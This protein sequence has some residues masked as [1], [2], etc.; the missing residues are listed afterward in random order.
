MIS[1]RFVENMPLI[2][3]A[4]VC[5]RAIQTPFAVLDTGFTGDLQVTPKM[6][7]ELGLQVSGVTP[8]RIANGE[9][10]E[11]PIALAYVAMEGEK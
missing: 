8:V 4:I 10:L 3:V 1:G 11:V 9:V 2:K 7:I 5:G 6:A